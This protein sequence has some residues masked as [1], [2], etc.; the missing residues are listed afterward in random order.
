MRRARSAP[1][2]SVAAAM[3]EP[4]L[5]AAVLSG[6]ERAWR[7]LVKEYEPKLRDAVRETMQSFE[8]GGREDVD[9][10]I[11]EFWLRIVDDNKRWLR[12]FN[13]TH[14]P[15][16]LEWLTVHVRELA[17]QHVR[18][19]V[20]M[21]KRT[22]DDDLGLVVP[23]DVRAAQINFRLSGVDARKLDTLAKRLKVGR[24]KMVRLI[25]EKFIAEHDP[26]KRRR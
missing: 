13:P 10:V 5:V 16:L 22:K 4:A 18:R 12:A 8:L 7:K 21:A 24:S 26:E 15:S 9:D 20:R 3:E 17:H 11:G 19:L 14:G 2:P 1:A 6:D 25:V 23:E